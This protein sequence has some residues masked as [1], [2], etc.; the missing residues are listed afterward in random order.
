MSIQ[1][2]LPALFLGESPLCMD[3]S[4]PPVNFDESDLKIKYPLYRHF[5]TIPERNAVN[6]DDLQNEFAEPTPSPSKEKV[7]KEQDD[8]PTT[9]APTTV[10]PNSAPVPTLSPTLDIGVPSL[11]DIDENGNVNADPLAEESLVGYKYK[12]TTEVSLDV[13]EDEVIPFLEHSLLQMII[14]DVMDCETAAVRLLSGVNNENK[15]FVKRSR[16]LSLIGA[17]SNP[18]DELSSGEYI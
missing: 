8:A 13:L 17:S 4:D 9:M 5:E 3:E 12:I 18:P 7:A 2:I 11:C 6:D 16:R 10:A 1:Q 15:S 14:G